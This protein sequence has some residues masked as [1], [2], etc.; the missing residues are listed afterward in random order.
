MT[1]TSD[2]GEGLMEALSLPVA[3]RAQADD[4]GATALSTTR[5]VIVARSRR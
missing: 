4:V 5:N 1:K 2:M 3:E